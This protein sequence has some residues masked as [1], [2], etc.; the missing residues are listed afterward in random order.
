ML[1]AMPEYKD[2]P[3]FYSATRGMP[4][5]LYMMTKSSPLLHNPLTV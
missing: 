3:A 4:A 2:I 5:L 1:I